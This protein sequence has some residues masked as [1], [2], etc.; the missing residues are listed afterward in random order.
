[1][2]KDSWCQKGSAIYWLV[3]SLLSSSG[4]TV[5]W[6]W[7]RQGLKSITSFH[8]L[9]P[10][11]PLL[12]Q[13]PCDISFLNASVLSIATCLYWYPNQLI[14]HAL[15]SCNSPI[16]LTAAFPTGHGSALVP[17]RPYLGA[18]QLG[19]VKSSWESLSLHHFSYQISLGE[20]MPL[21]Q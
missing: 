6:V 19:R 11:V 3:C 16:R 8:S 13:W 5:S 20:R 4:A 9:L 12:L 1:M 18:A 10:Q 21:F 2:S 17:T 14:K 15:S 7:V